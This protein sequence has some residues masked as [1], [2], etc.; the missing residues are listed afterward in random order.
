MKDNLNFEHY[1][2]YIP[3]K[4]IVPQ[5]KEMTQPETTFK[6]NHHSFK[7]LKQHLEHTALPLKK[8]KQKKSIPP[9][10]TT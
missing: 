9:Q 5:T 2:G 10:T 6:R 4:T 7:V 8:N 1:L 3:Y